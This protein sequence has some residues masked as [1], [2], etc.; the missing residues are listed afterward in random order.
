MMRLEA[1]KFQVFE[2]KTP[3]IIGLNMLNLFKLLRTISNN[4]TLTLFVD[5]DDTSKL[6]IQIDNEVKNSVTT[7]HA[8]LIDLDQQEVREN[9]DAFDSF[10]AMPSTDFQKYCRDMSNINS[11]A[12]EITSLGN[13]LI[14]SCKSD[15][16]SQKTVIE[17]S[18]TNAVE[19]SAPDSDRIVQGVF[20]LKYLTIFS[21]CQSVSPQVKLFIKNNF[22]LVVHYNVADLGSLRMM[23][24]PRSA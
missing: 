2:C 4:D 9:N 17:Q 3:M 7:Y 15:F 5:S 12:I 19:V 11:D 22:P 16:A 6:G 23:I 21:K 1:A 10:I 14:L 8:N 20:S 24:A 13:Q 18:D